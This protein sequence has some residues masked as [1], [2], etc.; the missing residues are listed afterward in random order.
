MRKSL[1]TAKKTFEKLLLHL[2]LHELNFRE[3]GS[4]DDGRGTCE[5][6]H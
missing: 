3:L 5:Q 1:G 4:A 2:V 6:H